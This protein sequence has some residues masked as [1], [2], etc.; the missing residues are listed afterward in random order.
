M[1]LRHLLF[2][3]LITQFSLQGQ[4]SFET[5]TDLKVAYFAS[6]CF[7]CVEAVFESV[8]GVVEAVSGYS[9]GSEPNP[10][11]REVSYGRTS[12]AEAVA[13]YYDPILRSFADLV[14]VYYNSHD[15][16]QVNGQGPDKGKQYRSIVFYQ[17]EF[18]KDILTAYKKA[19][20]ESGLYQKPI[21]T[22]IVPFER[23]YPAEDYHQNY[24]KLHPNDPYIRSVSIPRINRFKALMPEL[25]KVKPSH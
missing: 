7:W 17:N 14:A 20:A 21:A 2:L 13:V 25:L 1:N 10:T 16:T 6:G 5:N 18:E 12:H 3:L 9:G 22:E 19:V 11:Y 4:N 24:E 23:F 8:E 15:P